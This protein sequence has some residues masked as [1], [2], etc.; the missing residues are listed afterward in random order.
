MVMGSSTGS[1]K[2]SLEVFPGTPAPCTHPVYTQK[3][4][5]G[6]LAHMPYCDLVRGLVQKKHTKM[7]TKKNV[8]IILYVITKPGER[9]GCLRQGFVNAPAAR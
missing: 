3:Q 6:I 4:L 9:S 1:L 2:T 5:F 7:D 8:A